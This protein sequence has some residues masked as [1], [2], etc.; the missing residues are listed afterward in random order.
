M[1]NYR[2]CPLGLFHACRIAAL[3]C[4]VAVL[5]GL[6]GSLA[7]E[8][9]DH[10]DAGRPALP[11]ST[12]PRVAAQSELYEVV[13]ILKGGRLAIYLDEVA[14]NHPVTEAQVRVTI[15]DGEPID[16]GPAENGIFSI[17]SPRLAEAGSVG[18]I[19]DINATQGDDLLVGTVS[20]PQ[21]SRGAASPPVAESWVTS[22]PAPIRN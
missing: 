18:V 1:S 10:N 4:A 16:A 6:S 13:G 3:S 20:L 5:L 8:G 17:S 21:V 7:H 2:F 14:T 12:Y 22:V 15:G 19:F 11:T 9:H